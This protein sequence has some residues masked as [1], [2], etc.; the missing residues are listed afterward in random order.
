MAWA[1]F[2]FDIPARLEAW[3]EATFRLDMS[4]LLLLA[5]GLP[6]VLAGIGLLEL[7]FRRPFREIAAS[8]DALPEW[9]QG[10]LFLLLN[11]GTLAILIW[12]VSQLAAR[13]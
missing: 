10:L 12:F 7:L 13:P 1:L 3:W 5:L 8:W 6:V 2:H 11:V 4:V 9:V